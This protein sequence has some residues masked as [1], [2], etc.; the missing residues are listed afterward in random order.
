MV[1]YFKS[2]G[3]DLSFVDTPRFIYMGKDKYENEDLIRYGLEDDVWFH[4]DNLSSAHVY[5][6]LDVGEKWDSIPEPLLVDCAQLTKANSIEGN[7]RD[8][9]TVIYTPWANLKKTKGMADGEVSFKNIKK[10][11]KIHIQ[12]RDNSIINRLKKT[13]EE[14]KGKEHLIE[15]KNSRDKELISKKL[16]SERSK[17]EQDE[18]EK[19]QQAEEK[20]RKETLYDDLWDDDEME[21]NSNQ[22][23]MYDPEDDFW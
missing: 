9:I 15:A 2:I 4:V 13:R 21:K 11:K 6:R 1:Y 17:R 16:A 22:R 23:R 14:I 7:K 5:L 8:N 3:S 18:L 19:K 12:T 20:K 10:V